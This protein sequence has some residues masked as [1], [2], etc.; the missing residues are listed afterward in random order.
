M[1]RLVLIGEAPAGGRGLEGEVLP[2]LEGAVGRRLARMMEVSDAVYER[3]TTRYN[4]YETPQDGERWLVAPARHRAL[5]LMGNFRHGDRVILLG[6]K[7]E[8]AFALGIRN[9]YEWRAFMRASGDTFLVARVPHPSGRNRV[10]ND[11]AERERMAVFLREA[12][13]DS[14]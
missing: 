12:L 11:P 9:A 1:S 13:R 3:E 8:S 6:A 14:C 4:V 5:Q 7:V 2:A 10:L